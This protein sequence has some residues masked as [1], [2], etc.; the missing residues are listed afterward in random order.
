MS[1]KHTHTMSVS[2]G[3]GGRACTLVCMCVHVFVWGGDVWLGMFHLN[4]LNQ[5]ELRLLG[6][7]QPKIYMSYHQARLELKKG[8]MLPLDKQNKL[9]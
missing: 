9:E 6:S 5:A 4:E 7:S 3:V 1:E 8:N 2:V